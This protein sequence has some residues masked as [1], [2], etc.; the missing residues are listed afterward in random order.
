MM[1][2][3]RGGGDRRGRGCDLTMETEN[4]TPRRSVAS[5]RAEVHV[6]GRG[7]K[8]WGWSRVSCMKGP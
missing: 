7:W 3:Q 1:G 4:D 5:Q 2:L 6:R 8:G